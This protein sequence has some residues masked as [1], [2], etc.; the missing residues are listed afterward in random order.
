MFIIY[1]TIFKT[2]KNIIKRTYTIVLD[3]KKN[4]NVT[5]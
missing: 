2:L 4:L 1:Y 3:K 5:S